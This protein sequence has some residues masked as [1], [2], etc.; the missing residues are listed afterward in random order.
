MIRGYTGAGNSDYKKALCRSQASQR[1]RAK[2]DRSDG[3]FNKEQVPGLCSQGE[4]DGG[5]PQRMW[6]T[7]SG[8]QSLCRSPYLRGRTLGFY[9]RPHNFTSHK[10]LDV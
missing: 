10:K 7:F 9:A 3:G 1:V 5:G 4:D 6:E 8:L 2:G